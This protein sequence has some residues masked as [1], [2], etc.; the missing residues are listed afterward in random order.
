MANR[1][2]QDKSA[3]DKPTKWHIRTRAPKNKS[4]KQ[5]KNAMRQY[6]DRKMLL[7]D[8]VIQI[9]GSLLVT[10]IVE[11]LTRRS[12]AGAF[13]FIVNSRWPLCSTG[14]WWRCLSPSRSCSG[15]GCLP[16]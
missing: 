11:T 9:L 4:L 2:K 3:L 15:A 6:A 14:R 8:W 7:P 16:S 1:D 10:L 12:L 5:K 13:E